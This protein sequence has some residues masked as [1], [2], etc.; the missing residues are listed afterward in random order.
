MSFCIIASLLEISMNACIIATFQPIVVTHFRWGNKHIAAVIFVS[1]GW[2]A[3]FSSMATLLRLE[4]LPQIV[5]AAGLYLIGVLMFT[6]P[7]LV[8]WRC[9]VGLLLGGKA[10][11]LFMAPWT[12]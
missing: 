8:E 3:I 1:S 5:I 2:S 7:P 11:I 6:I 10:Q 12:A 4:Q 9:V